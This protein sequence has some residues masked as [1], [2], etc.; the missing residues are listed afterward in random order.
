MKSVDKRNMIAAAIEAGIITDSEKKLYP[1]SEFLF[2]PNAHDLYTLGCANA[3]EWI[4]KEEY[5]KA[6]QNHEEMEEIGDCIYSDMRYD[7][8]FTSYG[9]IAHI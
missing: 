7:S 3:A 9:F 2:Y 5:I 4:D 1:S 8:S 6:I